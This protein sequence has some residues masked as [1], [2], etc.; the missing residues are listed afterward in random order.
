MVQE[1]PT[2]GAERIADE[3][4]LKLGLQVSQRTIRAY[5]PDVPATPRRGRSH[6][7]GTFVRNHAQAL[8]AVSSIYW[9]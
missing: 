4:W 6:A 8:L 5:W 1:N 9:W 7:W 2:W 3:L